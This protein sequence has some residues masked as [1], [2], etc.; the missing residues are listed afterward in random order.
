VIS[1]KRADQL[2]ESARGLTEN[3]NENREA[4]RMALAIAD[5]SA[6]VQ[7]IADQLD[8]ALAR[9]LEGAEVPQ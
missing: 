7:P 5:A 8:A 2:K 1:A 6:A 4:L 9:Y 3:A